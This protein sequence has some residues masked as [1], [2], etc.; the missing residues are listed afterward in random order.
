VLRAQLGGAAIPGPMPF[1][2]NRVNSLKFD[3]DQL[4][5]LM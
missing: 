2:L 4:H 1:G 3:L 5:R